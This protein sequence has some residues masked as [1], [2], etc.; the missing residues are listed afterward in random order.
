MKT[1]LKMKDRK[2]FNYSDLNMEKRFRHFLFES[3]KLTANLLYE[4]QSAHGAPN[5]NTEELNQFEVIIRRYLK[6][7]HQAE[8]AFMEMV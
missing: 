7:Y 3:Y 5:S 4:I 1:K 2:V 6:A 8:T